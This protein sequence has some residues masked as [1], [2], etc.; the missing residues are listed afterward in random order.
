MPHAMVWGAHAYFGLGSVSSGLRL[1]PPYVDARN[2]VIA[3]DSSSTAFPGAPT[4]AETTPETASETQQQP[5]RW[6]SL[7]YDLPFIFLRDVVIVIACRFI[8]IRRSCLGI[9]F[10]GSS[11]PT[12]RRKQQIARRMQQ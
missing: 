2:A 1:P 5:R 11:R 3:H 7:R 6:S 9:I 10:F 8:F 4:A 12:Q